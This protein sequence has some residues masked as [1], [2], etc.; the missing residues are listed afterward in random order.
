MKNRN[1]TNFKS[2][3]WKKTTVFFPLLI[4]L[5]ISN[6]CKNNIDTKQEVPGKSEK[7]LVV[8]EKWHWDHPDKQS[9]S[10]GYTQVVKV[11]NTIYISGVPTNDLSPDGIT[12][13]YK[14]L[15]K[16][17]NTFGATSKDIV[18]ET[19]YTTDI[20]TMKKYNDVRKEF[21]QGDYPAASWVQISRLYEENAKLEVD[22]IAEITDLNK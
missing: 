6:N 12:R 4:I 17:L 18:K 3:H 22:L 13:L 11:G 1:K 2:F 21:Y 5:F 20:E 10:A 14:T 8:K 16:C 9:E 7:P 15:E 19:L